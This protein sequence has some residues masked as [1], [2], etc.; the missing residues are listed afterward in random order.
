MLSE[1]HDNRDTYPELEPSTNYLTGDTPL[2]EGTFASKP[3]R[4]SKQT[5][6]LLIFIS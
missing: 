4:G 1:D 5:Q 6:H 2:N 3:S